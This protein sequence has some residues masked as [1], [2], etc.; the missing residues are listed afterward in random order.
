MTVGFVGD[1]LL[2]RNDD[3]DGYA[4]RLADL[5]HLEVY[6]ARETSSVPAGRRRYL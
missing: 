5:Q 6:S 1:R 3:A 2:G 4:A